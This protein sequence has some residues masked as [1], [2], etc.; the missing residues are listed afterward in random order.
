MNVTLTMEG[1]NTSVLTQWAV[2]PAPVTLAMNW[3]GMA[4]TA[5]VSNR[6][7]TNNNQL[8]IIIFPYVSINS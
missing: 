3:M 2:T 6:T 1:V 5:L 7:I 8:I 4:M